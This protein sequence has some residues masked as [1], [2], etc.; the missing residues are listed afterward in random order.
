MQ[1]PAAALYSNDL[2]DAAHT[3]ACQY[4]VSLYNT[5]CHATFSIEAGLLAAHGC[6]ETASSSAA[7]S[8]SLL[9]W[10][11]HTV[12]VASHSLIEVDSKVSVKPSVALLWHTVKPASVCCQH[13]GNSIAAAVPHNSQMLHLVAWTVGQ[14]T[15]GLLFH[16]S[17]G[18]RC[19]L[20]LYS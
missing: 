15:G 14:Q 18:A 2:G 10:A 17:A 3:C 11:K 4:K 1:L 5:P 12:A 13:K 20:Q 16:G 7:P 9:L 8:V 6:I 19:G